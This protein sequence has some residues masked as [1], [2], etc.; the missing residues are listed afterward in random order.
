MKGGQLG[1]ADNDSQG[2]SLFNHETFATMTEARPIV[3][4][5]ET[6]YSKNFK[7]SSL[8]CFLNWSLGNVYNRLQR[9]STTSVHMDVSGNEVR[10][11]HTHSQHFDRKVWRKMNVHITRFGIKHANPAI[12]GISGS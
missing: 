7:D 9:L 10:T 5:F 8:H 12:Y 2:R 4:H 11:S 3:Q 6:L 1:E